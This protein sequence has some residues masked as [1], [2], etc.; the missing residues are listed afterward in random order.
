MD[1]SLTPEAMQVGKCQKSL[2]YLSS[3]FVSNQLVQADATPQVSEVV[4]TFHHFSPYSSTGSSCR[5]VPGQHLTLDRCE[6]HAN[7]TRLEDPEFCQHLHPTGQYRLHFPSQLDNIQGVGQSLSSDL[8]K[9]TSISRSIVKLSGNDN[10]GHQWQTP[11]VAIN[12]HDNSPLA[13]TWLHEFQ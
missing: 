8:S 4:D 10:S 9:I 3:D 7:H 13:L 1:I 6:A 5:L 11:L 2:L 12:S